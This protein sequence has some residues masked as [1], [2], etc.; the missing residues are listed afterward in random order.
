MANN[1]EWYLNGTAYPY[2]YA[3]PAVK[4]NQKV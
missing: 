1:K 4:D 2:E 3:G